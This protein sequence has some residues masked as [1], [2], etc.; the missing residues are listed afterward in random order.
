MQVRW[1]LLGLAWGGALAM[2]GAAETW[3]EVETRNFTVV[4]NVGEG[5]A[6]DAAGE[7]EQIRAA[8]AKLWPW[9]HLAESRPT[10]VLVLKD[11][12]TLKRWAPGY[13]TK[14]GIDVVWGWAEGADRD[15][16]LLRTDSKP[17][18]VSVAPNYDLY[19]AYLSL[20]LSAS[21]ERRLPVWLSNGLACVLGNVSVHDE[22]ILVG[23]PVPWQFESFNQRHRL[24]LQTIL[25]ARRDSPLL[26]KEGQRELF[27]AQCYMLVH[28]LLFG[29]SGAH[30]VGL[31]RFQELWNAGRGQDAAFS[32]AFGDLAALEKA[33]AAYAQRGVVSS[34]RFQAEARVG[35]VRASSRPLPQ[36]EIAGL[37]AALHVAMR[38]PVE[39]QVAIREARAADP[40]SPHS[41][42]AEGLLADLDRDKTRAAQA[43]ARAV[44]L[45]STSAYSHYRA[46]QLAWKPEPD[47][48]ALAAQRQRLERAI[49]IRPSY[50][51][52]YS[53][54]A[55][56]LV[57]QGDAQ[58]GLERSRRAVALEPQESYHRVALARALHGLARSEEA[59][60]E[61]DRGLKLAEDEAERSNAER[62]IRFL[63]ESSRYEEGRARL[64]A[65]RI[66]TACRNGD[67]A[68]CA[69]ALPG[70]EEACGKSD[71]RACRFLAWLHG[72]KGTLPADAAKAAACWARACAAGDNA[73]CVEHAWAVAQGEG[74]PKDE[75]KGVAALDALC[76]GDFLPACTRLAYVHAGRGTAA[77][78]ERARALFGKACRGGEEEACQ[79]DRLK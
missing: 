2:A 72:G 14:G 78:R 22:E 44:E 38:R 67:A 26:L 35:G 58:G 31:R 75:A 62:F 34:A 63:D 7:F 25:D 50:A 54:L 28:Y 79:M 56:V 12:R 1:G 10:V 23:R 52:A 68:A 40:G 61:A 76:N 8:Y 9:A 16:L 70:L 47:P 49:E 20:L 46:A 57:S 60:K 13:F 74:V 17:V 32:E 43:Y 64:E 11:E 29:K 41:Y 3:V 6:R 27:D 24:P 33:V 42:D 48:P 73:A 30:S 18:H 36:A 37:Q 39:A 66:Q 51:S 55:E 77:A 45:G 65:A 59:R 5:R 19:R 4:S 21:F 69:E 71:A 15:Y 53:F